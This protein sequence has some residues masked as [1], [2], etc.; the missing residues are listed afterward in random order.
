MK[1][2]T[3]WCVASHGHA[4][5]ETVDGSYVTYADHRAECE[6]MALEAASRVRDAAGLA[7]HDIDIESIV[8]E[9]MGDGE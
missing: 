5:Q 1:R 2:Y 8:R 6:R 3:S 7:G 9:V 4:M